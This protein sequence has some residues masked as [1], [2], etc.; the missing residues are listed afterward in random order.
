VDWTERRDMDEV[1]MDLTG[2]LM[3]DMDPMLLE[4]LRAKID[5]F[6]KWD[7]IRFFHDNP[8]TT[9]TAEN[10]ARYAG[11]SVEAIRSDLADLAESGVLDENRLGDLTVYSLNRDPAI[12]EMMDK[13]VE[14]SADRQFRVKAI[15]HIIRGT[16]G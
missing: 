12:R 3:A 5:S 16:P 2:R 7:L 4:F 8:Y 6:V 11:R 14:A 1:A 15:Y 9:D 10:I 13:F